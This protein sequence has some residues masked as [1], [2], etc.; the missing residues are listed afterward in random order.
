MQF[1]E[2]TA[3]DT[4]PTDEI[5]QY[6]KNSSGISTMCWKN[7][8]GTELCL[9]TSGTLVTGTG[10][11]D[12]VAVWSGTSTLIGDTGLTFAPTTNILT[13]TGGIISSNL[14]L[15]S[16]LFAGTA[17]LVSQDNANFFWDNTN[18]RLGIG[19][20]TP[21]VA[22]QVVQDQD[23]TGFGQPLV[24]DNYKS[25]STPAPGIVG[26]GA[27]GTLAAPSA[28]AVDDIMATFGG[29]GYHSGGAFHI[30]NAGNVILR[31]GEA[32]TATAQGS[33]MTFSTTP[34]LSTTNAE[35]F[36]IGPSGQWGI[37]GATFGT[38]GQ[39]F[40]SGGAAAAPTW[41]TP[42]TDHGALSGLADDDHAQYALLA[43]R[44]GGQT[45]IGGTAAADDLILKATSGV[46]AGSESIQGLVGNNGA[47][48]GF[49]LTTAN[50]Q[51]VLKVNGGSTFNAP[52]SVRNQ[53]DT[54]NIAVFTG[55][56]FNP[57]TLWDDYRDNAS[58]GTFIMRKSRGSEAAPTQTL[59]SDNL[60]NIIGRG[61]HDNNG[62]TSNLAQIQFIASESYTTTANGTEMYFYIVPNSSVTQTNTLG[63]RQDGAVELP[64]AA[65]ARLIERT[66]TP[67]NPTQ[68][69]TVHVYCRANK[70]IFQW[71]DAGTVRY[72]Y[73]DL[74]GTGVTWVHT[75]TAPT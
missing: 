37:G 75:T 8:A 44:T 26:R 35:R 9:P 70:I 30:T 18:N 19:T 46:G 69:T 40:T 52:F 43:G 2:I 28:L 34:L 27:R 13:V 72:K 14:T 25:A 12:Q 7:D 42:L 65:F 74:T 41:T 31:A 59:A 1:K 61:R 21:A 58:G 62:F 73:L 48:T 4:P 10:V 33:Y 51:A 54:V 66:A 20:A 68:D 63:L 38:A 32:L 5:R 67:A 47:I 36:R 53:S 50:S 71:N 16:V 45:L 23:G 17:G 29:R 60:G 57:N 56:G 3:P 15:G 11:A 39:V 22:L 55:D 24:L 49:S 64:A 6:A